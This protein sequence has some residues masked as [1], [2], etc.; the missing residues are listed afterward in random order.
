MGV[1]QVEITSKGAPLIPDPDVYSLEIHKDLDRIPEARLVLRDGCVAEREFAQS[2]TRTFEPGKDIEIALKDGVSPVPVQVFKGLV[3]RHRVGAGPDGTELQVELRD[4]AFALTRGRKGNVFRGQMDQQVIQEILGGAGPGV[5][6]GMVAPTKIMHAEL[7]QFN[8]TDWDFL[9]SR[10]DA[11]GLVVLVDDGIVSLRSLTEVVQ[12]KPEA[13]FEFGGDAILEFELELDAGDQWGEVSSMGPKVG[14]DGHIDSA[15]ADDKLQID[16]GNLDDLTYAALVKKVGGK[17][18]RLAHG[19]PLPP[20]ELM[21][22]AAAR[23]ARSRFALIRGRMVV[24]GQADLKPFDRIKVNGVGERF[25]GDL[26]VSGVTHRVDQDG[27]RTELRIGLSPEPFARTPN[28]ADA[29]AGGL[30]PPA[31]GLHIGVVEEF[32]MDPMGEH[33]IK[34][35]VPALDHRDNIVWACITRPD[36]GMGRGFAFWPEKGDKVVLGF[37]DNDPRHP[38]ILGSL[39]SAM[40]TAPKPVGAPTTDNNLR[41]IVSRNGAMIAFDDVDKDD[42]S[43]S[44]ITIETPGKNT[45]VINDKEMSITIKGQHGN[46]ITMNSDGINLKTDGAFMLDAKGKVTIMGSAV[47][48]K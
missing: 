11:N 3:L 48:L 15:T 41:A 23:L 18:N 25:N 8:A 19:A 31:V 26:L 2:N 17:E 24:E 32:D 5:T 45:I 22:V 43:K 12:A 47:E 20:G 6:A 14:E 40:K 39:F 42:K 21:A 34:V 28:I 10:A 35:R 29:P 44:I 38:V 27:W 7:T 33:R 1:V 36:A 16:A 13:I 30:L 37:V 4:P 9:V 46:T